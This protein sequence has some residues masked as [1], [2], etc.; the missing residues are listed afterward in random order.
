MCVWAGR[1]GGGGEEGVNIDC[2][3]GRGFSPLI[4]LQRAPSQ[5]R[6]LCFGHSFTLRE[7]SYPP[8]SYAIL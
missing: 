6:L 5:E 2:N 1:G 8:F 3:V 7:S 4:H